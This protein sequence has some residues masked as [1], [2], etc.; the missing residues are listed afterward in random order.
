LDDLCACDEV[1]RFAVA[2]ESCIKI[3][4][5]NT[6]TE[7]AEEKIEIGNRCGRISKITW[8]NTGQILIVSTFLGYIFAFN[9][10]VN[11]SFAVNSNIICLKHF[12][13]DNLF[14]TLTSLNE[15]CTFDISQ[16]NVNKI[17]SANLQDEPKNIVVSKNFFVANY[18][19]KLQIFKSSDLVK[20][21]RKYLLLKTRLINF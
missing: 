5:T 6:W 18:G 9:V 20:K 17:Y 16:A 13:I 15:A 7:I 11:E 2:G 19:M 8:S 21:E 4:D 10:I 1:S 3:Y 14:T 12:I